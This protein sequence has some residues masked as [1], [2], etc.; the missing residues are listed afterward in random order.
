MSIDEDFPIAS[1]EGP[2]SSSK[3]GKMVD[4]FSS[5]SPSHADAFSRDS[6]LVK[7][8]RAHYFTTHP[9]DWAHG[10]M[11]NL[12]EIFREL[13]PKVLA[14]WGSPFMNYNGHGMDWRN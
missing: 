2:L 12:S 13:L 3:I 7:E 6:S 4:W 14:C 10:N 8:A 11:D 1:Q 5:L 9:W